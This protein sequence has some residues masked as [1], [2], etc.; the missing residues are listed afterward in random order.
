MC[1]S[2]ISLSQ[3]FGNFVQVLDMSQR[4]CE[5]AAWK[6]EIYISIPPQKA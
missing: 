4:N 3:D 1:S 6:Q 5:V 2:L